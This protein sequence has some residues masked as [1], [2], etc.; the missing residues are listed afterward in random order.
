MTQRNVNL[1]NWNTLWNNFCHYS[2]TIAVFSQMYFKTSDCKCLVFGLAIAVHLLAVCHSTTTE[3][4]TT[5]VSE[6][7]CQKLN[8]SCKECVSNTACYYCYKTK[9]CEVF[10]KTLKPNE[11][12]GEIKDMAWKTCLVD[13]KILIIVLGSVGGAVLLLTTICCCCL[14][15][16]ARRAQLRRQI[17]KW[18]RKRNDMKA[19][20]EERRNQR[21][22][23]RQQIRDKY[24]L[25]AN[26]SY[27]RFDWYHNKF[28]KI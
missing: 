28:S 10:P 13:F 5:T 23:K 22:M 8:S 7:D 2:R 27:S 3:V 18:E 9:S 6:D 26:N 19:D 11:K 16:K 21:E 14:C 4:P 15:K 1:C 24:G 12:C 20:Q 17:E 25:S